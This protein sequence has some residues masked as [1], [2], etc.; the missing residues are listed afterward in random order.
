M[1]YVS[2]DF[3][4]RKQ[5]RLTGYDYAKNGA[6]FI[7]ICTQNRECVFGDVLSVGARHAVPD[8]M[9]SI[10]TAIFMPNEMGKIA[11]ESWRNIGEH[12][13]NVEMGPYM[14]MPNH[15]H[16][17]ICIDSGTACRAPTPEQFGK[18]VNGSISTIIRSFK[19][20]VTRKIRKTIR[21]D[22]FI[23]W[24]RSYY[25]HVIRTE[26]DYNRISEYIVMNPENWLQDEENPAQIQK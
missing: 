16:G 22:N 24:Q 11:K 1:M 9:N 6:Y 5:I 26:D 7:T 17:I 8:P 21:Q 13:E 2:C 3:H 4:N 12:F 20:F 23:V 10:S 14:I 15:M 25:E 18:P 19:S